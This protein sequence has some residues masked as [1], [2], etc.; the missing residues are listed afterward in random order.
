MA[1]GS[2]LPV[3]RPAD[4][5]KIPEERQS[6]RIRRRLPRPRAAV[7]LAAGRSERLQAVT[8][9]GSKALVRLGGL[10]LVER[11][12]RTLVAAGIERVVVVVGYHA[13]PV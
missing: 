4:V 12:V 13:G 10:A 9:G 1:D 11:T 5:V 7:I 2:D 6:A 3:A 8:G